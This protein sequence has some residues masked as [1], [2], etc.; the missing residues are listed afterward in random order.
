MMLIPRS[1]A[2][3]AYP[4]RK[5]WRSARVRWMQS[6]AGAVAW[7]LRTAGGWFLLF[8]L[9]RQDAARVVSYLFSLRWTSLDPRIPTTKPTEADAQTDWRPL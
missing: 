6:N 4:L 5:E 1:R 7:P 8:L 9:G 2:L 3:R